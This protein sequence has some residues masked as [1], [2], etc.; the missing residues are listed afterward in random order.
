MNKENS[1]TENVQC[2]IPYK[3]CLNCG[4]ELKGMYCHICGQEATSKTPTIGAYIAEYLNNAFIWDS[5]FFKTIWTL[6]SRPGHL[7]NEYLSGKFVSQEHPLKL[8]MFLLFVFISLFVFFSG[9]EKMNESMLNVTTSEAVRSGYQFEMLMKDSSYVEK[10]EASPRDTVK[11]IAPFYLSEKYPNLVNNPDSV[12]QIGDMGL[13]KW[14]AVIPHVLIEDSIV[15]CDN[16]GY[17]CFNSQKDTGKKD[18]HFLN[19]TLTNM[20]DLFTQYFPM[21]VLFTSPILSMSLALVRRRSRIPRFNHFIFALHYTAL[22]E[23]LMIC[24]YLLHLTIAPSVNVLNNI[25][26][27]GSCTYLTVAYRRVYKSSNWFKAIFSALMTSLLY[28]LIGIAIF[29]GILVVAIF[30]AAESLL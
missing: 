22:L 23:F 5:Q 14:V 8:N 15:V 6:I 29:L 27:I 28:C 4:A 26:L 25:M 9:N 3:H 7:T 12:R 30:L 1:K 18:L 16:T 19:S 10:M 21:L 17:Y 11:L 24:I 20:V 13:D 2:N